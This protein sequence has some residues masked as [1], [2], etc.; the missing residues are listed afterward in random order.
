[1]ES[2]RATSLFYDPYYPL[3][4]KIPAV[5]GVSAGEETGEDGGML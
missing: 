1:M 3:S 2:H 4:L 5:C